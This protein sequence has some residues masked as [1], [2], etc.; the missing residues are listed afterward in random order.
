MK[1]SNNHMKAHNHIV[2]LHKKKKKKLKNKPNKQKSQ[3]FALATQPRSESKR[4]ETEVSE[5][6]AHPKAEDAMFPREAKRTTPL[7][8]YAQ[9]S[10]ILLS[11]GFSTDCSHILEHPSK[12]PDRLREDSRQ[13]AA[14][15]C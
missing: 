9:T 13:S 14:E 1:G 12:V 4:K 10:R 3:T 15:C 2:Y 5:A 6:A 8:H 7:P 11:L